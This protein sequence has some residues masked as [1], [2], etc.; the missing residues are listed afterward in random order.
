MRTAWQQGPWGL[1]SPLPPPILSF[2]N[3]LF[4]L[5]SIFQLWLVQIVFKP[6]G[7]G[8]K[9]KDWEAGCPHSV[10]PFRNP[11]PPEGPRDPHS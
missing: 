8:G 9:S 5:S 1:G 7:L 3:Q 2:Q 11:S 6:W 4:Q 10:L